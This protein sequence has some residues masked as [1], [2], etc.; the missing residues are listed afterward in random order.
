MTIYPEFLQEIQLVAPAKTL[1]YKSKE[2]GAAEA[3]TYADFELSYSDLGSGNYQ[4]IGGSD[5]ACNA[6][7]FALLR[8][9][10]F[11]YYGHMDAFILR[12]TSITAGL[13]RAKGKLDIESPTWGVTD[14]FNYVGL[15]ASDGAGSS[16]G[17]LAKYNKWRKLLGAFDAA[18][19]HGHKYTAITLNNGAFNAT[20]PYF[21]DNPDLLTRTPGGEHCFD[22]VGAWMDKDGA[23]PTRWNK[24]V[25]YCARYLAPLCAANNFK[26]TFFD[27]IDGDS[28][29]NDWLTARGIPI[30]DGVDGNSHPSDLVV[31]FTEDVAAVIRAGA[32]SV[33][34]YYATGHAA[35]PAARLGILA[36]AGHSRPPEDAM[37][38]AIYVQATA[39]Y[40]YWGG[41]LAQ[42]IDGWAAK[43]QWP[44]TGYFYPDLILWN[45]GEPMYN[46][47]VKRSSQLQLFNDTALSGF[48]MEYGPN[49]LVN[50]VMVNWCQMLCIDRTTTYAQA[51]AEIVA[52]LFDDDPAVTDIFNYWG[53]PFRRNHK[54][55]MKRSFDFVYA[56]QDSW[57]KTYFKYYLTTL[58]KYQRLPALIKTPTKSP[59]D[60]PYRAAISSYLSNAHAIRNTGILHSYSIIYRFGGW[61][62]REEGVNDAADATLQGIPVSQ[63][64]NNLSLIK[65]FKYPELSWSRGHSIQ[66]IPH[67][68]WY[69]YPVTPSDADFDAEYAI[70]EATASRDP[71]LSDTDLVVVIGLPIVATGT[72]PPKNSQRLTGATVVTVGEGTLTLI[73]QT[74]GMPDRTISFGPGVEQHD[75]Y[76][77]GYEPT[78][79]VGSIDSGLLFVNLGDLVVRDGGVGRSYFVIPDSLAGQVSIQSTNVAQIKHA[80][81][82]FS[83]YG[84]T[85]SSFVSPANLSP[86]VCAIDDVGT[87]LSLMLGNLPPYVSN[88]PHA[89]LMPKA[90]VE[91]EYPG[92]IRGTLVEAA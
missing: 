5:I 53:D 6:G 43:S 14:G 46:T 25:N 86:G 39:A 32:P 67:P 79:Y 71:N 62:L 36:Y 83:L 70:L 33:P 92:L 63:L 72:N 31:E 77:K 7:A 59:P 88:T 73:S 40:L 55:N 47:F 38:D 78:D 22:L 48:N 27:C 2:Q 13:S 54:F 29:G 44:I 21:V 57:Y 64:E 85:T 45:H 66:N 50:C 26:N 3:S 58:A 89:M 16:T 28:Y 1:T 74:P 84:E 90:F 24:I 10:G 35:V 11:R 76:N 65:Y 17:H 51:L 87:H 37:S 68:E 41:T 20:A 23:D 42:T 91:A 12:P 15:Y 18:W 80:G 52:T 4:I 49:C 81:G 82:N 56:M 9:L 75:I 69:Q 34:G 19:P 8:A 30:V 60:D 61:D